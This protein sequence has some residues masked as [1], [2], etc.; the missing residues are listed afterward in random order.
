MLFRMR[1]RRIHTVDSF[2]WQR[3]H[4]HVLYRGTETYVFGLGRTCGKNMMII[5]IL[6]HYNNLIRIPSTFEVTCSP[7]LFESA[8][9]VSDPIH[10][11]RYMIDS[12]IPGLLLC[13]VSHGHRPQWRFE[14]SSNDVSSIHHHGEYDAAERSR[15]TARYSVETCV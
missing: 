14:Y 10:V 3:Y 12:R 11:M 9:N 8:E 1:N 15:S 13:H 6:H 5:T 2:M 7:D 4:A